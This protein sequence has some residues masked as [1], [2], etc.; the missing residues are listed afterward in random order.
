MQLSCKSVGDGY[1]ESVNVNLS[2]SG[3]RRTMHTRTHAIIS[4]LKEHAPFTLFGAA[5]G[6]LAML[7]FAV[8]KHGF[9]GQFWRDYRRARDVDE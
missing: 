6:I 8:H 7:L 5:T 2:D 9:E 1:N 4:E 3:V